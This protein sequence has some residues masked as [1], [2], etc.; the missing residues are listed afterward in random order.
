MPIPRF[1]LF[2]STHRNFAGAFIP[3]SA[4][5]PMG[6]FIAV[7]LL[8]AI[9][10]PGLG[11]ASSSDTV[12]T[13]PRNSYGAGAVRRW[14]LGDG[15]RDLWET[16]VRVEVLNLSTFAGGLE[17]LRRGGGQQTSSLR[18]RGNDGVR[19]TFR[20]IDKDARRG[21]DPLLRETF[22]GWA[23]QDQIS[24]ILPLGAL[25]VAP[26]LEAAEV[27]H[28]DPQLVVMPDDARLGEYREEFAGLLGFIE[29]RPDEGPDGEPGF[30]GSTR[31]VGSDRFLERLEET[32][33][34]SVDAE[35]FLRARLV[36]AFV[37]DWDRHPD[38]WR[39]AGFESE[40]GL[41]FV[42]VPRDRDWALTRL[43]GVLPGL[44]RFVLPHY[45]GFDAEYPR[46]FNLTWSGRALDRRILPVLS[47]PRWEA[48][49]ADLQGK[50]T[51]EVL[52]DAVGRL[53]EAYAELIG[54]E[55]RYALG[56]RRDDLAVFARDFYEL[57]AGWV[58]IT[59]TDE[60]EVAVVDLLGDGEVRV[61][62]FVREPTGPA[63]L[64]RTF[65]DA[66]TEE[67]RIFLRGGRDR[68]TVQGSGATQ[69]KIRIVG[70]G[71]DDVFA[72]TSTSGAWVGFYDNRGDNTF[73]AAGGSTTIDESRDP[74][75]NELDNYGAPPRDWGHRWIK[76][77]LISVGSEL[78]A[79]VE[80][81]AI[82]SGYGFRQFPL[83]NRLT[84]MAGIGSGTQRPRIVGTFSFPLAGATATLTGQY[85]GAERNR[86]FGFGNE[87]SFGALSIAEVD[88]DSAR[89]GRDEMLLAA[90]LAWSLAEGVEVSV[91]SFVERF[92]HFDNSDH[93]I[94][95]V[96][97][98]GFSDFSQLGFRSGI[99]VRS[100]DEGAYPIRGIRVNAG[101]EWVP[102]ALDVE[103]AYGSISGSVVTYL[104]AMD[105]PLQ[106][107]LALRVAGER[108]WGAYPYQS[109]AFL[110]GDSTLRGFLNDRFAGDASLF[111]S[112]ELRLRLSDTNFILP[113]QF[114]VF[115][116]SD[117]GRV[118][119]EGED[120]D[121]W[122]WAGGGGVWM[123]FLKQHTPMISIAIATSSESTKLYA[124]L[125]FAY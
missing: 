6:T 53:P 34:N 103:S 100:G 3:V 113:G 12:V 118:W 102:S 97:P 95:Q 91:G 15:Y 71:N 51:D 29:E 82:R 42:P 14:I 85:E 68:A 41:A 124:G 8:A 81:D 18:L 83:E 69:M 35:A 88:S 39:W 11:Q 115:G 72:N 19:Y 84:L 108:V 58:D 5:I 26:L 107:T 20:S 9:P 32:P 44:Y 56:N 92:D 52:D 16:P 74:M 54:E 59:A 21:L 114:G 119:L 75:P 60:D 80:V 30:E 45:I 86:F 125:G 4:F 94:A 37:G 116:L 77:P 47:W 110:G 24:A 17:P 48:V 73:T 22:V 105:A 117:V 31:V 36:D 120:S 79:Y 111:G 57:L 62:L 78:G 1:H 106:P 121:R 98:F 64:D 38:Q 25:V 70:G 63:R 49:A 43:D 109:A 99:S 93:L 122:H 61:R 23:Q 2:G 67:V 50:L 112:A 101:G 46:A 27:L 40:E 90:D 7:A 76:Y 66:E 28:A 89:V 123:S 10:A 104:T 87:S 33:G 13:V 96:D 65:T 55:L